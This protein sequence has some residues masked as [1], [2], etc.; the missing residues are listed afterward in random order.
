MSHNS[1]FPHNMNGSEKGFPFPFP[2]QSNPNLDDSFMNYH[3]HQRNPS[4]QSP[5]DP[6]SIS[7]A[8]FL[9]ESMDYTTLSDAFDLSCCNSS[10]EPGCYS[11]GNSCDTPSAK[12]LCTVECPNPSVT[13][14]EV[15]VAGI[16]E[17]CSQERMMDLQPKGCADGDAKSKQV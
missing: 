13:S 8:N 16:E 7:Y 12:N 9:N 3:H 1:S 2:S 14:P 17:D 5:P 15:N 4:Q 10:S 11:Y 6:S